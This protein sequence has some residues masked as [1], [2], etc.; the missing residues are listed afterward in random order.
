MNNLEGPSQL[1]SSH[2]ISCNFSYNLITVQ[3]LPLTSS[4]SLIPLQVLLVMRTHPSKLLPYEICFR[5]CF[6]SN[7]RQIVLWVVLEIWFLNLA[8][9]IL[10]NGN[11][12]LS[13]AVGGT[14]DSLQHAIAWQLLSQ[15]AMVDWDGPL[16]KKMH[17]WL[18]QF[19][20]LRS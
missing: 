20:Y 5:V 13:L 14:Q 6:Q 9:R 18:Q 4:S 10:K 3:P 8:I 1:Q 2:W 12:D 16:W 15:L 11:K 7:L 19:R 17:C